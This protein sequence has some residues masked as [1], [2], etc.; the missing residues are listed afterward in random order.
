MRYDTRFL[1]R[2]CLIHSLGGSNTEGGASEL[3]V[4][5][6][7]MCLGSSGG[8]EYVFPPL[9]AYEGLLHPG[10]IRLQC[11]HGHCNIDQCAVKNTPQ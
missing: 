5:D 11:E 10:S 8:R 1:L 7:H 4:S 2:Q 6:M 3:V 9:I